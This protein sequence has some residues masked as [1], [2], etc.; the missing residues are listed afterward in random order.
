MKK[1]RITILVVSLLALALSAC[2]SVG[3]ASWPG[4][5][6]NEDGSTAYIANNQ[7]VYAVQAANGTEV[8]RFPAKIGR[9]H[10]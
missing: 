4:I 10:V 8:W 3:P 9:A 7:Y 1:S 6:V 2:A 5:T